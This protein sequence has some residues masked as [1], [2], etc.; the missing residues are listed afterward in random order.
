MNLKM[1][2]WND[3]FQ[4]GYNNSQSEG[5]EMGR[6]C[7]EHK[8]IY[9]IYTRIGEVIGE[10]SGKMR[11]HANGMNDYP[12]VGDWVLINLREEEKKATINGIIPR[13]SKISRK[14]AGNETEEQILAANF[15]T[16]FIVSSLNKDFNV[17]RIERYLIMAWESGGSP[18]I[19]LSKAD[20]CDNIDEKIEEL[21]PIALGVPIHI[22]SSVDGI[23]MREI[24]QYFGMGKTVA[25]LGSSGVGKST[26]INHL[27]KKEVLEVQNIREVD[28]RGR[29]TT[30]HRQLVILPSGGIIIDTPGMREFQLWDGDEGVNDT[31]EDINSLALNCKFNDCSHEAEPGCAVKTAI[32]DGNL[33]ESRYK[34]FKKLEKELIHFEKRKNELERINNK[35]KGKKY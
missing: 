12:A 15:D 9:R 11:F 7:V 4:E 24:E 18:V 14:V 17:R 3:F 5:Y 30:T 1:L 2:G 29:H 26:L 20:L 19:I 23:G 27:A 6:I 16:V 31:F 33:L 32:K 8:H 28:D 10:I 34:S 35:K 21:L 25:V 13:K 22:I